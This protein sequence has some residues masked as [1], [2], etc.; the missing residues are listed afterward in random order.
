MGAEVSALLE[1]S[2]RVNPRK[3]GA[4]P[5]ALAAAPQIHGGAREALAAT[6]SAVRRVCV[7]AQ[8]SELLSF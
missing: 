7:R 2:K 8:R 5:D 4:N 1:G 3:P 6:A